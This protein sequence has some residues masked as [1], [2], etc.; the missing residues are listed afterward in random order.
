MPKPR[1]LHYV[2]DKNLV[3]RRTRNGDSFR[4]VNRLGRPLHT[5][6][7][8]RIKALVIPPAWEDVHISPDPYGHIQATGLDDKGRKQYIYHPSWIEYNQ[9]HKFDSLKKFGEVLPTLR[10]VVAGHMRQHE[11]T[12]ERVLATIVWLLEHTFIRVGNKEYVDENQ[13]YGLTTMRTKHVDVDG[14]TIKF[15]FKGKSH[16]YHELDIRNPRVAQ[17]LKEC[18]ELPGYQI[19]KY[20]EEGKRRTVDAAEVNAYLKEIS[21]ESLSAKDFRTWGGTILAGDT[22][23][24]MGEP[25][26]ELSAE[27][28]MVRAVASVAEHLGNTDAVCR[29]YYIHPKVIESYEKN[30]LIPHFLK[31]EQMKSKIPNGLA[32]QEYATWSLLDKS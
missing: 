24:E 26:E 7:A 31:V 32:W 30:T 21:G 11:L 12:R 13:S 5:K 15:S 4:F 22:L 27:K 10:E 16:V 17:T 9:Q 1:S 23:Y 8:E 28:V 25:T 18:I 19:F 6:D 14:N 2:S 3:W 20:L 29:Q